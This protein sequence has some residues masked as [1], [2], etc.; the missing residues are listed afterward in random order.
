MIPTRQDIL[1][2]YDAIEDGKTAKGFAPHSLGRQIYCDWFLSVAGHS[3]TTRKGLI[4]S[5]HTPMRVRGLYLLEKALNARERLAKRLS[6]GDD[7]P[8]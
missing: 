3:Y 6:P 8:S 4:I 2:S 7:D 5:G 1:D